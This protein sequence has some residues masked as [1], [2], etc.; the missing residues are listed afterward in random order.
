[1]LEMFE[2]AIRKIIYMHMCAHTELCHT[3]ESQTNKKMGNLLSCLQRIQ[4][5]SQDDIF[6][7]HYPW[8]SPRN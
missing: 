8:L 7:Y 2:K 5:H 3:Q 1:M 6:Y 4:R